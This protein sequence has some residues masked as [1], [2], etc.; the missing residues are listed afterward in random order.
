MVYGVN[1]AATGLA[2]YSNFSV[3]SARVLNPCGSRDWPTRFGCSNPV[4]SG[5]AG[6]SSRDFT[7]SAAK[8]LPDDP[9]SK[10]LYAVTVSRDAAAGAGVVIPEPTSADLPAT[11]IGPDDPVLV[12]FRAYLNPNTGVGPAYTDVIADRA[13]VLRQ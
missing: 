10:Y 13:M 4:W 2:T 5:V 8:Y 11:G 1:H 12:G 6:M 3:Y 9:M 7:D